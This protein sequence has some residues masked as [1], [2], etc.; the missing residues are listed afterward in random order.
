MVYIGSGGLTLEGLLEDLSK[1]GK[2]GIH[3]EGYSFGVRVSA[4][5]LFLLTLRKVN[6][7]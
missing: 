3:L 6:D 2:K 7:R 4:L 1:L 5:G